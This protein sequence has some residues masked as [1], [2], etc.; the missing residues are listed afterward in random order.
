[1]NIQLFLLI[2]VVITALAF[3]FTNGFHDTGNAMATS[4]ASGAL[5]PK[6]AV[7]LSAVLNLI[8]AFLSTAVAATIAKGLIDANLVTL[9]LVFAGL[10]GG[11]VWN[12]L[13]WL[14][15]IPSS[16][17]HA[18]I[19]GIVG[20]TIAAVGGHGVI[21]KGV[22]SKVLI[23]A[24]IAA[25]L[26]IVVGAAATWLVYR[27]TRGTSDERTEAGFRR[28]QIG[29][30][31]LVSLAHGT[32]DAQ[33]TMGVIFLALM[34]YGS[35]SKTASMPPLWVIVCCALAMAG[36]TYLGGWRIIRTL[37]KGLVEIKSPQGM[38]AESSSAAV[39]LL[40]AHFGYALSTTQVC[41]GSVLGSGVG[42]PGAEVRWGV[43]GRMATAWLVTLPL[44]GLVGAVTYW[45]VHLIGGYPGA[46]VGFAMLVAV[47]ATI[48]L[49]S[50]RVKVDHKNVNADWEGHLTAGLDSADEHEL[51]PP[52]PPPSPMPP[53]P[54]T[55]PT[56]QYGSDGQI[57]ARNAS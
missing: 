32:N 51:S 30:A 47:A 45:I 13:T 29:S 26:A 48:Y 1:M 55:P 36:G 39:I 28:G 42:K 50:R 43:A 23:P 31:S 53:S 25:L 22:I 52:P 33:K 11:I 40:S 7:A 21:W 37:G 18:L 16:S 49:R 5:A 6:V 41:T 2:I 35:V 17:S 24:V 54:P 44:S 10:V 34:S 9:E 27:I 8:G 3:D 20:A 12:L 57:P 56:R 15:G 14:L 19:G 38:A 46:I 4:I